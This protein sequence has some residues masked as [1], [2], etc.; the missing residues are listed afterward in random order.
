MF[1]YQRAARCDK[2]FSDVRFYEIKSID[3]AIILFGPFRLLRR[4]RL[5]AHYAK[6]V[7]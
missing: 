2:R 3:I 1:P 4:L 5:K 7:S 6:Y